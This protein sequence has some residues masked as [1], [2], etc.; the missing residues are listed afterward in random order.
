M[1]E[2]NYDILRFTISARATEKLLLTLKHDKL[3]GN[4]IF[5]NS[6]KQRENV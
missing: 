1:H 2:N 3:N 5:G 6:M 4:Y